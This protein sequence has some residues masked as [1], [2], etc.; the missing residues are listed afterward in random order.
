M[1]DTYTSQKSLYVAERRNR[2]ISKDHCG[3]SMSYKGEM[4]VLFFVTPVWCP[5]EITAMI[6]VEYYIQGNIA[7]ISPRCCDGLVYEV[8]ISHKRRCY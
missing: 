6:I 1:G 3:D 5:A 8:R 2:V 4:A 7:P